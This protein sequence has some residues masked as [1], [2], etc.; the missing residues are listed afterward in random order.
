M[1]GK[2]EYVVGNFLNGIFWNNLSIQTLKMLTVDDGVI[3]ESKIGKEI[4]NV[5]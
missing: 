4:L 1:I 3:A 5:N 2:R